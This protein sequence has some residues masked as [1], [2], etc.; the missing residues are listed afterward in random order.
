VLSAGSAMER[1]ALAVQRALGARAGDIE[2]WSFA[3]FKRRTAT[4][5]FDLVI[6]MPIAWPETDLAILWRTDSPL[7]ARHYSNPKLDAAIDAGDWARAL[8]ELSDDPPVAFICLPARHAIIDRRF[9][10]ARIG[11]YGFFESLPDWEVDR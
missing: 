4:G 7:I 1:M 3:D 5:D 2:R 10:N 9:K 11:P 8:K 6:E